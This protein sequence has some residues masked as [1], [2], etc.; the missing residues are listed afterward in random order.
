MGWWGER[1]RE[2]D[3]VVMDCE[4][5]CGWRE[6]GEEVGWEVQGGVGEEGV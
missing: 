5:G 2:G 1:G 3:V 4:E 6:E